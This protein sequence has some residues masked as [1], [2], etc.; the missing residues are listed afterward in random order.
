MAKGTLGA[1]LASTAFCLLV[2]GLAQAQ[3]A[4]PEAGA[5]DDVPIVVTARRASEK[6]QDV[7]V[8]VQAIS[9]KVLQDMGTSKNPRV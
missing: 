1:L 5:A 2:P 6:L 4:A 9:G 8:S 3:V 7:P